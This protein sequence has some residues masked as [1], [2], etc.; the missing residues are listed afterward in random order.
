M[1]VPSSIKQWVVADNKNELNGLQLQDALTPSV[2]DND[3]LIKIHAASLNYRD[4]AIAKGFYST[5]ITLPVVPGSDAAGEVIEVGPRVTQWKKGD[6]VLTILNQDHQYGELTA[7]NRVTG[8]G[9][10]IDGTLRQYGVFNENG[11]VKAPDNLDWVEAS[12]LSCAAVTAWNAL[13]GLRPLRSGEWVLVQGTGG[14]S[15]FALQFAKAAGAKVIATT[16]SAEKV[17]LLKNLGADHVINYKED[18]DWGKTAKSLTPNGDGVDHVVEIGGAETL[19]HSLNAVKYGGVVSLIGFLTGFRP[20]ESALEALFRGCILRGVMI[21]SRAQ[22]EDMVR[23][24]EA[25]DIR[26]VVD[27]VVFSLESVREAYEYQV[28]GRCSVGLDE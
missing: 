6:R 1:S 13:Y 4:Q 7:A 11:L 19:G 9:A 2:G 12:T 26:P 3:V 14:V 28:C 17:E 24:I 27:R 22:F 8:L 23:A 21:G 18:H 20:K 25:N 15:L 5:P 16:S 10:H